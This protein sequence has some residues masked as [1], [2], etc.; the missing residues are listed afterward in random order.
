MK[1]V[2]VYPLIGTIIL[3]STILEIPLILFS[4]IIIDKLST[5]NL[6]LVVIMILIQFSIYGIMNNAVVIAIGTIL[7]KAA[8]TMLFIM[9]T[10]K[11]ISNIVPSHFVNSALSIATTVK[12]L[13]GNQNK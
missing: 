9:I 7:L 3:M 6:L 2:L 12:A 11:A 10:L 1:K 13:G 8:S 5:K 4:N